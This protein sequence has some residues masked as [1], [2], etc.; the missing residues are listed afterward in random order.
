MVGMSP[1]HAQFIVLS[2]AGCRRFDGSEEKS[3]ENVN[4]LKISGISAKK[5]NVVLLP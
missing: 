5:A 2:Q 3:V 4:L 1:T